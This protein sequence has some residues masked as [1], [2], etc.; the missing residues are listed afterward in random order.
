MSNAHFY[1][2]KFINELRF[3]LNQKNKSINDILH[4]H[5]SVF[6]IKLF[7]LKN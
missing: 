5:K 6:T 7:R 3:Y 1:K 2:K 4:W